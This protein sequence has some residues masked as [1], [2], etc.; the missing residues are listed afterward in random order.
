MTTALARQ[1]EGCATLAMLSRRKAR[2]AV[3]H[4]IMLED[5]DQIHSSQVELVIWERELAAGLSDWLAALHPDQCPDGRLLVAAGNCRTAYTQLLNEADMPAG[6]MRDAFKADLVSLTEAFCRTM[7]TDVVDIRLET[8]THDGCWK[9]HR[10]NV[11]VRL[12]TTYRGPGTQWVTPE[13]SDAALAQQ[14]AYA[15]PLEQFADHTVGLFKGSKAENGSGIVHRSPPI[16]GTGTTRILLCL[17]LPSAASP[18]L[19]T[20]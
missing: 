11:P 18:E 19:Q 12:L 13:H 10:D 20:L 16:L 5:L 3:A 9:Y 17:N 6:P 2:S 7:D 15:G 4:A 8:V 1:P 14:K